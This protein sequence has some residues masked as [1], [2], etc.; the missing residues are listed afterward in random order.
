MPAGAVKAEMPGFFE[1]MSAELASDPPPGSDWL[2]E[3]KWDGVRALCFVSGQQAQIY[4]RRG[5]RC[6][7]QYPELAVLPHYLDAKA[8]DRGRRDRGRG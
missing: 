6:E 4:S 7:Q 8:S 1:P 3:V 5:N 2:F